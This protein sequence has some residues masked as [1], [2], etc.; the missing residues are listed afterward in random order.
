MNIGDYVIFIGSIFLVLLSVPAIILGIIT[1]IDNIIR[2]LYYIKS[3]NIEKF[4]TVIRFPKVRF[5]SKYSL[6]IL[7]LLW[8][9]WF[10]YI[11]RK[12]VVIEIIGGMSMVLISIWEISKIYSQQKEFSKIDLVIPVISLWLGVYAK[13]WANELV[14]S[15]INL[16]VFI[17]MMIHLNCLFKYHKTKS[18]L[19]KYL[20]IDMAVLYFC[21][22]V[23]SP[24]DLSIITLNE[25]IKDYFLS[26]FI[27]VMIALNCDNKK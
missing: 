23:T 15:L 27:A 24:H 10:S 12:I 20:L 3:I 21:I 5:Y 1:G 26:I 18:R 13:S 16:Y 6:G 2:F 7:V 9:V 14:T 17:L 19:L 8:M 11:L 25:F 4:K 22:K